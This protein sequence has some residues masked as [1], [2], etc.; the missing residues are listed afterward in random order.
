M[1]TWCILLIVLLGLILVAII[2]LACLPT[3]L[4]TKATWRSIPPPISTPIPKI[5]HQTWKSH[6]LPPKF[7][8]WSSEC[9]DL[10]PHF[11]YRLWTDEDNRNLIKDHYP[12]FLKTYDAYDKHIKRV[13]AA[14]YFI[15]HRHGGV[16]LDLDFL[17]LRPFDHLL[18]DGHA[19]FGNQMRDPEATGAVANAWMAAPPG[20]PLFHL[21]IH[22]L[23]GSKTKD[24]LHATGP[25][26][27]TKVIRAY[28][29]KAKDPRVTIHPMPTIYSHQWNDRGKAIE[30]CKGS[31][32]ACRKA[33]PSSL[34]STVWT[35]TWK[36]Q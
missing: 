34:F 20:H 11:T 25:R 27:L 33:F 7:A 21:L 35:H 6:D 31:T 15:L 19:V 16:Y 29:A 3:T 12:W 17:C 32:E 5:L 1:S 24:V 8:K 14:R 23:E 2:L 36:G 22:S 18:K 9:K 13:D 10:A 28:K 30:A 26:Y 4:I